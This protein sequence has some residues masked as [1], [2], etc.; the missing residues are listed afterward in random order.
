MR[1]HL[2]GLLAV[3]AWV[4]SSCGGASD[5]SSTV[6]TVPASSP[7]VL[8]S[9]ELDAALASVEVV[10]SVDDRTRSRCVQ[11]DGTGYSLDGEELCVVPWTVAELVAVVTL[12][13][14]ESAMAFIAVPPGSVV[15]SMTSND[16]PVPVRSLE[17]VLVSLLPVSPDV[18]LNFE[19][20]LVSGDGERFRCTRVT[21]EVECTNV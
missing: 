11:L 12:A 17:N 20:T 6:E 13:S 18:V 7:T 16:E 8:S 14:R 15:E 4:V 5:G 3:S 1:T 9:D 10:E 2:F 21:S 19:L